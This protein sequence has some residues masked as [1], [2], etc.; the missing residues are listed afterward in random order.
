MSRKAFP[1]AVEVS[2]GCSVARSAAPFAFSTRTTSCRSAMERARRS[3]RVT[4]RV[5]PE[6]TK[7]KSVASSVLPSRVV[8]VTF[9]ERITS[10]PAARN[11]AS[12]TPRS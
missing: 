6:R 8:P 10:Q 9:S 4:T 5:S 1:A 7:S 11:A 2:I 3:T 12:C